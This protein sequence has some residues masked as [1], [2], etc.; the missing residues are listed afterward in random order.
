MAAKTFPKQAKPTCSMF[1][2]AASSAGPSN[3]NLVQ[4]FI[5]MGF[6]E[7]LVTKAIIESGESNTD[8][9]LETILTY[10]VLEDSQQVDQNTCHGS[11]N[12]QQC[13]HDDELSSDYDDSLDDSEIDDF[14]CLPNGM[15][16]SPNIVTICKFH[17]YAFAE[18]V[19]ISGI[20]IYLVQEN[21]NSLPD[22]EN[23]LLSLASMGYAVEEVSE[24][25]ERCG[26]DASVVDLIEFITAAQM[27]K[28]E[29]VF[30]EE[31]KPKIFVNMELKRKQNQEALE[32]N[33]KKGPLAE[34]DDVIRLPNPMI[35]FGVPSICSVVAYRTLPEAAIGPP[36]FYYENVALATKGDW[37]TISRFLYEITP[38][39]VDSK[40]FCAAARKR[41][42]VHNL[43]INN[44]F[45]LLPLPPRTIHEAFPLTKK[46]W[47]EWDK[48][49]KFNCLKTTYGSPKLT[50]MVRKAVEKCGDNPPDHVKKYV[51]EE[52]RRWNLVWV[53]KN[54]VATLEPDEVEMILGF[55]RNHTRGGGLS[56]TDR[57]KSLG[58]SFQVDTVAYHLSVL[59]NIYPDG[60]NVLSLFSGIGGAEVALHKLRIPLKNVVSVELSEANRDIMKS[61]WQQTDQKGNLVHLADVQKLDPH[62]L[63]KLIKSVGGFDLIIGGSPC[64]NM[65]G[66]N[67]VNRDGLEGEQSSLFYDYFRILETVKIIMN[68]R[69]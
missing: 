45:P 61:W 16:Q 54:K 9:I 31:E 41:G 33:K 20:D 46:W 25:M 6:H 38:E 21:G 11:S 29:A 39:F 53:G 18:I 2:M 35:G 17:F 26:P 1:S 28:T 10:S 56:R 55:P 36:F 65:A 40:Y 7:R 64:N 52:C 4:H 48:R 57:F 43:P 49:T 30:F 23:V 8:M 47:P 62:K 58:N 67:R 3:S 19:K 14:V 5:N 50:E 22:N 27:A 37:E 69:N 12:Q 44:R 66:S 42:Y 63:D 59:K 15:S 68:R 32:R 51:L 24:A 13:V 34:Q 60:M